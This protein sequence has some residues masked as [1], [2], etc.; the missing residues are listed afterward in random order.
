M[1]VGK[2][3]KPTGPTGILKS[4]TTGI[5]SGGRKTMGGSK[6][7]TA[8]PFTKRALGRKVSR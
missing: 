8:T 6:G 7:I 1:A 4:A 3:D 5:R 2:M